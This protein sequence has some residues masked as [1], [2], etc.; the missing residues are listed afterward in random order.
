MAATKATI[1]Y[2]IF[3]WMTVWAAF[4]EFRVDNVKDFA[5]IIGPAPTALFASRGAAIFFPIAISATA[6]GVKFIDIQ[7]FTHG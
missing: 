7:F 3:M 2:V 5:L 1:V 6:N 4:L